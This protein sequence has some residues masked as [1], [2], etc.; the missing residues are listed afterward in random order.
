MRY[1]KIAT[2]MQTGDIMTGSDKGDISKTRFRGGSM[3]KKIA[4]SA[5]LALLY[6]VFYAMIGPMIRSQN[7]SAD[8]SMVV[9]FIV[10]FILC[11]VFNLIL[12]F[13]KDKLSIFDKKSRITSRLD[14]IGNRRLFFAVWI[15]LF[16]SWVP[17]L[18]ITFPGII[19]Y[20]MI[21][22]MKDAMDVISNNHHPVLHTWL[23]SVFMKFGKSCFSSYETGLGFLSVIQMILLSYALAR[24]IILIRKH[25]VSDPVVIAV[26]VFSAFWFENACLSVSQVKDTLHAAF[27][28]LFV[29][30]FTGIVLK[31]DEYRAQKKNY[32]LLPLIGFMMCATRNNGLHIYLFCFACLL[33]LRIRSIKK[34]GKF[35]PLVVVIVLPVILFKVYTGP[36]FSALNIEQGQV[37]EALCVPIQ[38]LQR[39]AVYNISEL[40][41]ADR[42]KINFYIDSLEWIDP[43]PGRMYDPFCADPAKS[44]F[45]SNNYNEDPAA[46][47]KF[48]GKMGRRFTKQYTVAFLSNSLG[49]WYPGYYEFSF[50][51]F[52]DYTPDRL[53]VSVTRKSI[54]APKALTAFYESLCSDGKWRE[55]PVVRIFFVPAYISWALLY[56]I[57]YSYSRKKKYRFSKVL[58][59]FLPLIAQF[60]IMMLCPI[61]SFRYAWPLYLIFPIAFIGLKNE[62]AL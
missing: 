48:W 29:C 47:W 39:I 3:I 58:P 50:V 22:Q 55:I 42:D 16:L 45:Y 38:Q 37:R 36:V 20:D 52:E 60:G 25:G 43:Y 12:Y 32:F 41:Q 8:R 23:I 54:W 40:D 13:L 19:S 31:P 5:A 4:V 56:A 61:P 7:I 35:F 34:A 46:F 14:K 1:V 53:P 57:I 6:G 18:L 30:H 11:F 26:T 33:L 10:C 59:L 21:S 27:L 17:A 15:F 2:G 49:F 51:M 24:M 44:C 62:E 9:P 28:I